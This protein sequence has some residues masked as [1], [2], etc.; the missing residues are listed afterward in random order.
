MSRMFAMMSTAEGRFQ[1]APRNK[2]L[3]KALRESKN[4]PHEPKA[5]KIQNRQRINKHFKNELSHMLNEEF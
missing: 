3:N 4:G 1:V 5:G 2:G